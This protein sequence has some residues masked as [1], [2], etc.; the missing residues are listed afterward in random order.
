MLRWIFRGGRRAVRQAFLP[1]RNAYSAPDI[2]CTSRFSPA[3][4]AAGGFIIARGAEWHF[5]VHPPRGLCS[6]SPGLFAKRP[7]SPL[8]PQRPF[9]RVDI[10]LCIPRTSAPALCRPRT[11]ARSC[12]RSHPRAAAPVRLHSIHFRAPDA[13]PAPATAVLF[14]PAGCS[15]PPGRNRTRRTGSPASAHSRG[16]NRIFCTLS[17]RARDCIFPSTRRAAYAG[18]S[19]GLFAKRPSPRAAASVLCRPRTIARPCCRSHP[20]AAALLPASCSI[21]RHPP[22]ERAGRRMP[23][24]RFCT[25]CV[26]QIMPRGLSAAALIP[27]ACHTRSSSPPF[28]PRRSPLFLHG[29]A[30]PSFAFLRFP[31]V[32][33]SDAAKNLSF[34]KKSVDKC[35]YACYNI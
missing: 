14:L 15:F 4:P 34:S 3:L 27:Y 28:F 7:L 17:R 16:K 10:F 12:C 29:R 13:P 22:P 21:P 25:P 5:S 2:L 33:L 24:P 35:A 8:A 30:R 20:R 32:C 9:F 11:I 1:D 23:Y 26:A 19:P 31:A 18:F 6:F